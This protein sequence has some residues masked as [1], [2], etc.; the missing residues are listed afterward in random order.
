M[1][2]IADK[3][4][5]KGVS[6]MHPALQFLVFTGVFVGVFFV[7]NLIGAG[8]IFAIYGL[9]TFT[10]IAELN[11]TAPHFITAVWILQLTS[12]TLPILFAPV[13]FA[14]SIVN[15]TA[16]YIKPGFKF[17]WILI[18]LVLAIMFGSAPF[19]ELLSNLN[20]K[21]VLP[22]FLHWMR[23]SE[24]NAQKLTAALLQMDNVW[25]MLFNLIF[26]G[27]FTAIAEEFM[28]RG[29]MQTIFEKWFKNTHVA[30]WVTAILFS[31]FHME[32]FGFLPR[33]FLGVV[34]GY[35][36]AYSG[37]IWPAVWG[38][39]INNGT[40]VIVTYLYQHKMIATS[41]DDDHVFNSTLY[42]ISFI[43]TLFLFWVYQ[44]VATNK[45]PVQ[46]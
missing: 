30:I 27:L 32:F 18:V 7:G 8:L 5:S 4:V 31:A 21:M 37:S 29:C 26:I 10:A 38:H 13:L 24:D 40:A 45:K 16:G 46:V 22:P 42:I 2:K 36:V 19:M 17:P 25:Q 34:F 23:E 6:D 9:K 3:Q 41:P 43:I 20:Q 12:T 28:F 15:D 35:F 33:M 39:F 44:K 14:R 11:V 1:E